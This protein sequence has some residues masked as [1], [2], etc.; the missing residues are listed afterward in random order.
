M[1]VSPKKQKKNK[2]LLK[3]YIN[4]SKKPAR[5]PDVPKVNIAKVNKSTVKAKAKI[6]ELNQFLTVTPRSALPSDLL[7][8][9]EVK[10]SKRYVTPLKS[11]RQPSLPKMNATISARS[12]T[13]LDQTKVDRRKKS[14]GEL[15]STQPSKMK[16]NIS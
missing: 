5:K 16:P 2:T 14:L 9:T 6:D 11:K 15:S 1:N 7:S 4:T 3:Q 12:K 13:R 10:E 8:R